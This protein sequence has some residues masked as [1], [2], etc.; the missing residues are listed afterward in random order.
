MLSFAKALAEQL[1]LHPGYIMPAYES[2]WRSIRDEADLPVN[3]STQIDP[4]NHELLNPAARAVVAEKLLQQ[5]QGAMNSPKGYVLP[6]KPVPR[7]NPADASEWA[8]SLWPLRSRHLFLME[9]DSPLG[10]RLPLA[11]LPWVAPDDQEILLPLDPMAD[12]PPLVGLQPRCVLKCALVC[13]IFSCRR[14]R[15]WK[16]I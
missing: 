15:C 2:L 6:L 11:A 7:S 16:T 5:L 12:A 10:L 13:Y 8:S 1:H 9:G 4:S 14:A 3:I